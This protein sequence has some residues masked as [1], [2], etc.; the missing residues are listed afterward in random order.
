[1]PMYFLPATLLAWW[2]SGVWALTNIRDLV[3]EGGYMGGF[4]YR[5]LELPDILL[6]ADLCMQSTPCK[7]FNFNNE[8]SV[9]ELSDE[10]LMSKPYAGSSRPNS[11]YS[12]ISSWPAGVGHHVNA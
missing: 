1:M 11:V 4:V 2:L 12:D 6:C 7:A 8:T 10:T 9:C 5:S 3:D